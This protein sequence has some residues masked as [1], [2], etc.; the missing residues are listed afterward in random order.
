MFESKIYTPLVK[1]PNSAS[2]Q[3]NNGHHKNKTKKNT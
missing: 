3:R 2:K 1:I